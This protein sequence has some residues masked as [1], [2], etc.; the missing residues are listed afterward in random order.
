M[1]R[2]LLQGIASLGC[3]APLCIVAVLTNIARA[4]EPGL[5][6]G[7]ELVQAC[8]DEQ[9]SDASGSAGLCEGY[10]FGYVDAHPEIAFSED[11]PS[12]YMQRVLRTRAP[13]HPRADV[14]KRAV[15]CLDS[16]ESLRE[17]SASI[18]RM[19]PDSVA[20]ATPSSVIKDILD[21]HY[22]CRS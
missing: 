13:A 5:T 15:Y 7:A 10:L 16:V 19:D 22:R 1:A 8:R 4:D 6:N 18:A 17:I 3:I 9:S 20:S 11:L 12:E 21:Q 2:K 14:Q